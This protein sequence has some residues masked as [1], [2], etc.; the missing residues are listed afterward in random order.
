VS[1]TILFGL[2]VVLAIAGVTFVLP[3]ITFAK[4]SRALTELQALRVRLA[5][6]EEERRGGAPRAP[7]PQRPPA[8]SV[9]EAMTR[10]AP[11]TDA[12][13][14]PVPAPGDDERPPAPAPAEAPILPKPLTPASGGPPAA[15]A[16]LPRETGATGRLETAIGERLLLYAGVVVFVLGIGFFVKYAF[17]REW[18]TEGMRVALGALSGL[19]LIGAGLRLAGAGYGAYGN[20]LAGGGLAALYLSAYAAF[21]FYGLIGSGT[22]AAA[23]I[24]ITGAAAVLADRQKAQAMAIMAVGGGFL[25]P[26]LVG[27]AADAQITLFSYV[28]LLIAGTMA[29]AHHRN[30][31]LLNVV[32]YGL[33]ILTVAA[34]ADVHYTPAKYL[35]TELFLTLY[36][37]MFLIVLRQMARAAG[38]AKDLTVIVLATAPVLYHVASLANLWTH[39]V[40]LLVYLI[41]FA[42]AGTVWSMATGVSHRRLI[43]WAAAFAPFVLWAQEHQTPGLLVPSMATLG[44]LFALPLV[45]Q[46]DRLVR[47]AEPLDGTDVLLLHLNALGAFLATWIVLSEV[48]LVWVPR[49]GVALAIIHAVLARWLQTRRSAAALHGLAATLALIA[50]VVAVELEGRWLTAVWAAEGAAVMW[51]GLRVGREWFRLGGVALLTV[52]AARWLALSVPE[53]PHAFTLVLNETFALGAWIIGLMY[54]LAWAHARAP[55]TSEAPYARSIAWLLVGASLLT[56]VLLTAQNASYWEIQSATLA[57]A[58][59]AEQLVLSL[60]WTFYGAALIV[61]GVR[62]SYAPIRYTGMTLIAVTVLKVFLVDLAGLQGIYRVLGLLVVGAVLLAISFLYQRS[63]RQEPEETTAEPAQ[64]SL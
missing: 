40:A 53:T 58:T 63:S 29:L 39:D 7:E 26:F 34:W 18:I 61:I 44:A 37:V 60:L 15:A 8:P 54:L 25:T 12:I 9:T 35:R 38:H 24:A 16:S 6:L 20:M 36:C 22:A 46:V 62:S 2:L 21:S 14:R 4:V 64:P 32:S 43:T 42:L 50:A 52:G 5:A 51:I 11:S 30:W 19:T 17:D 48:S 28:A 31:P 33:T 55:R 10:P 1:I 23:F 45:A 41:L 3:L 47:R 27:G 56:I 57:D 59:F 13:V 49:V